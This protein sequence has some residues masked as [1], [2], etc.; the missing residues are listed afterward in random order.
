MRKLTS[1]W[2]LCSHARPCLD[3]LALALAL[4]LDF[5]DL[6]QETALVDL[7]ELLSLGVGSPGLDKG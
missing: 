4:T 7:V 2:I 3:S 1:S 6:E 5:D